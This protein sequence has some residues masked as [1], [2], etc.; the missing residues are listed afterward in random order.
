[1][2]TKNFTRFAKMGDYKPVPGANCLNLVTAVIDFYKRQP[3]P[4][5]LQ[6]IFLNH[7]HWRIFVEDLKL[8]DDS[9]IAEAVAGVPIADS[10]VTVK[11]GSQFQTK[12]ML[13]EFY[14]M[15]SPVN[16]QHN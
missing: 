5:R 14:P 16:P 7:T 13:Y 8:L 11:R 12:E 1:M 6:T 9:Y 2:F 3:P 10:D 15:P 4:R